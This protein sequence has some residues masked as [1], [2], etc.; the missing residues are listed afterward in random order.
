MVGIFFVIVFSNLLGILLEIIIPMFGKDA[1]GEYI[2][3]HYI[4]IPSSDI[5]FNVAM[6]VVSI[7]IMLFVQ[8][9]HGVH[10]KLSKHDAHKLKYG[11]AGGIYL[12]AIWILIGHFAGMLHTVRVV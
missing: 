6:S 3:H 8:M 4:Q 7:L 1:A 9:S 10:M 12:T 11:I 2:L 5:N